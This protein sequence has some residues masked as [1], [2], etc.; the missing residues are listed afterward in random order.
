MCE[1]NITYELYGVS[2]SHYQ[3]KENEHWLIFDHDKKIGELNYNE[4][5]FMV[6]LYDKGTTILET[7][8]WNEVK[9]FII[10]GLK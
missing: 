1:P 6:R 9:T 2:K 8:D 10:E 4:F 3:G 7:Q 5:G